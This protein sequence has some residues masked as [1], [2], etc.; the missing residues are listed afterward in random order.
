MSFSGDFYQQGRTVEVL[1]S[2]YSYGPFDMDSEWNRAVGCI[3][4][5]AEARETMKNIIQTAGG[6]IGIAYDAALIAVARGS[7]RFDPHAAVARTPLSEGAVTLTGHDRCAFNL[8]SAAVIG[9]IAEPTDFTTDQV[10]WL[11]S[12]QF[13]CE[14]SEIKKEIKRVQDAA[15]RTVDAIHT[16]DPSRLLEEVDSLEPQKRTVTDMD[17]D[18]H[19]GVWVTNF[20]PG[21]ALR[22]QMLLRGENPIEVQAYHDNYAA[23][24]AMAKNAIRL[25]AEQRGLWLGAITCRSAATAGVL[26]GP[27]ARIKQLAV[28]PSRDGLQFRE[29][30]R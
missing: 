9:E 11:V 1:S 25:V 15:K 19:A 20:H 16:I 4:P 30:E 2:P 28:Q 27:D 8:N 14:E 12:N 18:N 23:M 21:L 5:R 10:N 24:L 26:I 3:D 13:P 29:V 22:R 6:G 7:E 17:G